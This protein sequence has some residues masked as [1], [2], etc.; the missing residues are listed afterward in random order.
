MDLGGLGQDMRTICDG[1][2]EDATECDK[3]DVTRQS[4][5]KTRQSAKVE[6]SGAFCKVS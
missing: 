1:S 5:M 6:M 4:A 2:T 3:R